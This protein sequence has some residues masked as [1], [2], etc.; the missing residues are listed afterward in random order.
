MEAQ[1]SQELMIGIASAIGPC[2][3]ALQTAA[4]H[5]RLQQQPV[6]K[7]KPEGRGAQRCRLVLIAE[8]QPE[9]DGNSTPSLTLHL[10]GG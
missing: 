9:G 1:T 8:K 6:V 4:S 5:C 10:D 3:K 2:C 7:V